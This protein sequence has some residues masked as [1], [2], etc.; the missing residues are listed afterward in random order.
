MDLGGAVPSRACTQ[1]SRTV[2]DWRTSS[3]SRPVSLVRIAPGTVSKRASSF[4]FATVTVTGRQTNTVQPASAK[5]Q[6]DARVIARAATPSVI[7]NL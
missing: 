1:Y 4:L 3:S 2:L 7:R 5:T 6:S